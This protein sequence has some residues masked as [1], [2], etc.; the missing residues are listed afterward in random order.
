M[1]GREST[2]GIRFSRHYVGFTHTLMS[3]MAH[4]MIHIRQYIHRLDTAKTM[5][6]AAFHK[7][8]KLVCRHHGFDPKA[9]G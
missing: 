5:H 7:D 9:F 8:A 2:V 4:E 6:N 3:V 1:Q